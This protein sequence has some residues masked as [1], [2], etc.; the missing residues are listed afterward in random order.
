MGDSAAKLIGNF[1][2]TTAFMTSANNNTV[3]VDGIRLVDYKIKNVCRKIPTRYIKS[4][5]Y[6]CVFGM[7]ALISYGMIVNFQE[8]VCSLPGG[9]NRGS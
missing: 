5:S 4:L 8:G 2:K 1:E 7:D 3:P 9:G 6:G